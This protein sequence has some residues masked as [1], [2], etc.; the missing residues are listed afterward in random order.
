MFAG[1]P[2]IG[3]VG[4]IGSGKSFVARQF[5]QLG[6]LVIDSDQQVRDAYRDPAVKSTLRQWWGDA[7]F[8][9][10]GDVDRAALAAKV[11]THPEQRRRLEGLVHPW[12]HEARRRAMAAA[13]DDPGVV[14]FVW[15]TPLLIEAGLHAE[16]DAVVFV[17]APLDVRLARVRA[18]R[19]WEAAELARREKSQTPL[20]TKR[21]ISDYQIRNTTDAGDTRDQVRD[22][23]SRILD[24]APQRP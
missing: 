1:K 3:I 15:D 24:D 12:V 5:G 18:T 6:C 17:D 9:P 2:I 11:F 20:D 16:C 23:L 8:T 21:G 14:A 19:G 22:V 13:A 10:G 4:G 7:A